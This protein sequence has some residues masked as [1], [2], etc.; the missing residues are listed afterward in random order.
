MTLKIRYKKPDQ[1]FSRLITQKVTD[2]DLK[3]TSNTSNFML[4]V[5]VAEFGMLLR[6]SEFKGNSSYDHVLLWAKKAKGEDTYGY[7]A[8]LI[9]LV[10][11]T[12]L[13]SKV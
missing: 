9:T 13:L 1:D 2:K 12:K 6:D 5:A 8:E 11:K 10:E 7:V 4:A 3:K